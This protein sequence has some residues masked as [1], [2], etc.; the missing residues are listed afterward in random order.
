MNHSENYLLQEEGLLKTAKDVL[1]SLVY[2]QEP[3][4]YSIF[5]FFVASFRL[6]ITF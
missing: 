3:H 2:S 6:Q 1:G 5:T 4:V